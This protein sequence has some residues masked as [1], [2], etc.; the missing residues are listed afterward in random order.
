MR[1][2]IQVDTEV[3]FYLGDFNLR[4]EVVGEKE[5]LVVPS[6]LLE[7]LEKAGFRLGHTADVFFAYLDSFP[8]LARRALGWGESDFE[9]A[10]VK[11][12]A[13]NPLGSMERPPPRSY[14]ALPPE[15]SR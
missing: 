5:V 12:R 15:N 4:W 11:V 10:M 14:G 2:T 7:T 3:S 13:L 9:K 8:S 1:K 6:T